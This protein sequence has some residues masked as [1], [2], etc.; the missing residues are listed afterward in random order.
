MD[1]ST[2]Q[3]LDSLRSALRLLGLSNREVEKRLGVSVGYLSRLFSGTIELRFEHLAEL[4]RV[5]E[6]DPVELLY[7][8]FPRPKDPPSRGARRLREMAGGELKPVSG[9]SPSS[10]TDEDMERLIA[11]TLQKLLAPPPP[12]PRHGGPSEEEV[13]EMVTRALRRQ[14]GGMIK[15]VGEK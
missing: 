2:R 7:F 10:P 4:A 8:A 6:M 3:M 9:S 15:G 14:L 12:P 13:E 5:L 11:K 1:Q